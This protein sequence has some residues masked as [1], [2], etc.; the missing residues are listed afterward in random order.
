MA[1][2]YGEVQGSR[3][4][5]S[6]LG[7]KK[8]GIKGHICGWHSGI[9]V[10]CWVEDGKDVIEG[11][12]TTGPSSKKLSALLIRLVDRKVTYLTKKK[13]LKDMQR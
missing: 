10:R 7:S 13:Y 11:W 12:V 8:S 4:P 1:R 5:T 6:R 9:E 3:G 2:F